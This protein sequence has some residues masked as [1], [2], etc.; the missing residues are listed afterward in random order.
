MVITDTCHHRLDNSFGHQI[1]A[2]KPFE[3]AKFARFQIPAFSWKIKEAFFFV[4]VSCEMAV[5]GKYRGG[6]YSADSKSPRKVILGH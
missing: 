2:I 3:N 1:G 5:C 6:L 4:V